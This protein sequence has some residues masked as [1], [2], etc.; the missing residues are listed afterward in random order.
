MKTKRVV[1]CVIC[2][3][4]FL[5][6]SLLIAAEEKQDYSNARQASAIV[7]IQLN[8]SFFAISDDV[9]A[10]SLF[11]PAIQQAMRD[12]F[13]AGE[14]TAAPGQ[15]LVKVTYL[16]I[17]EMP[18]GEYAV[19]CGLNVDL[20]NELGEQ[21]PKA[22]EELKGI[23]L[24]R[25]KEDLRRGYE[26]YR[27]SLG[28]REEAF[29]RQ[30]AEAEA[31]MNALQKALLEITGGKKMSREF[32]EDQITRLSGELKEREFEIGVRENRLKNL[33]DRIQEAERSMQEKM[34]ADPIPRELARKIEPLETKL[35]HLQTM[36]TPPREE[37]QEIEQHLIEA[38]IELAE[39]REMASQ[40]PEA[41]RVW[42]LK[43][44]LTRLSLDAS[45]QDM[46][47]N[48][49]EEQI[50]EIRHFLDR[51]MEYET[52]RIKAEVQRD[53]LHESIQ[54]LEKMRRENNLL[55]PPIVTVI[56]Q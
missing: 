41:H 42:E 23:I 13:R 15:E 7:R 9:A 10:I 37:I 24:E 33:N 54:Q 56:S 4:L 32:L 20:N 50:A 36:G 43:E 39:R 55:T 28:S 53:A 40:S 27:Q 14:I 35:K 38:R 51:S 31:Q 45:E 1:L 25:L 3:V 26:E 29:T 34:E 11:Q 5:N 46:R 21:L 12:V 49:L 48:F 8:E 52:L 44:Q 17:I 2:L 22:A 19:Q 47:K 6:G 18:N 16:G 30:V